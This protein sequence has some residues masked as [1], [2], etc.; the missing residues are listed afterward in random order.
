MPDSEDPT[1]FV[2]DYNLKFE[3]I[4]SAVNFWLTNP[5]IRQMEFRWKLTPFVFDQLKRAFPYIRPI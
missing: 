1:H 5:K 2:S 4:V 3:E